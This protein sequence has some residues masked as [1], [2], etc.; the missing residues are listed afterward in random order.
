M[1]S[2]EMLTNLEHLQPYFQPIFSADEHVVIGYEI[3][4]RYVNDSGTIDVAS[5]MQDEQV[6]E[7]YRI[8][9]DQYLLQLALK[10]ISA[11]D[12]NFLIFIRCEADLLMLDYGDS[13][14]E[15]LKNHLG[16]DALSRVVIELSEN[17]FKGDFDSLHHLLTYYKTYGIKIAIND[18]GLNSHLE[19]IATLSPQILKINNEFLISESWD[20]QKDFISSTGILARKIG[21]SLLVEG[22]E[23][24]YQLQFAWKNGVRYYQGVYLAEPTEHFIDREQ[25]K[26]K[27]KEECHRFIISEKRT[28]ENRYYAKKKMQETIQAIVS[29]VKPSSVDLVQLKN[30]A[31]LLDDISFRLY[32]CDEDGFQTSPNIVRSN[33]EWIIQEEYKQKNWSWRPYF[34][35]TIITMRNDQKGELSDSYSDIETG[36]IIRTFSVPLNAQEYLFIDISYNYLFEHDIF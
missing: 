28:L 6:P 3:L 9:V 27:F 29:K 1:D 25:L 14:L 21:A 15:L 20:T 12:E 35:K 33:G 34:L 5:L 18:L 8:E 7:E 10:K 22:I 23:D 32:V 13:L 31:T 11:S 24:V 26:E 16:E 2:M 17:R 19:K 36:E 4:G 30:L